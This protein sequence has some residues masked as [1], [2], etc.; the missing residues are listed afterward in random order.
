MKYRA[1]KSKMSSSQDCDTYAEPDPD[2][3]KIVLIKINRHRGVIQSE[4]YKTW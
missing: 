2:I 3:N 1:G 4:N